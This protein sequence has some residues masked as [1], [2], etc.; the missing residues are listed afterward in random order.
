MTTPRLIADIGGT[1]A[2]FAL[3]EGQERRDEQVLACADYPDLVSAVEHYLKTVGAQ[4]RARAPAG[5]GD[6]DRRPDH[7]R[8][9]PHDE[10][11]LAVLRCAQRASSW[12]GGA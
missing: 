5:S 6:G 1:N 8:H 12:A 7:R 4:R 9:H 10:S 3:L 2:R 11:R